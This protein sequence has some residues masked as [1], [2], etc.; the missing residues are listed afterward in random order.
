VKPRSYWLF[1][2]LIGV[3]AAITLRAVYGGNW[4][5]P[6]FWLGQVGKLG[7]PY[8]IAFW[9][10]IVSVII[11]IGIHRLD[12]KALKGYFWSL[13]QEAGGPMEG[14]SLDSAITRQGI[15]SAIG[16]GVAAAL[17]T[18]HELWSD[19]SG[20]KFIMASMAVGT[21]GLATLLAMMSVLCYSHAKRWRNLTSQ[22]A[23]LLTRSRLVKKA[24]LLDQWSWYVLIAGL[25]WAVAIASVALSIWANV[26][27]VF[28]LYYY[29]FWWVD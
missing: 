6:A 25:L 2:S 7:T 24:A 11:F 23:P 12:G 8:K 22:N 9:T 19:W 20:D 18:V 1:F 29:Y 26:A 27:Y 5:A 21:L 4:E 28:C 3:V 14:D 15:Q 10:P 17:T 16:I 13:L